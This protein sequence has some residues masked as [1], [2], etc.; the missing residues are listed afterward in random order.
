[1]AQY[2][3]VAYR[4]FWT[5][6]VCEGRRGG[7]ERGGGTSGV[8]FYMQ[9][10][11]THC[12]IGFYLCTTNS[13]IEMDKVTGVMEVNSAQQDKNHA[14]FQVH[15]EGRIYQLQAQSEIE[16]K[17]LRHSAFIITLQAYPNACGW[18]HTLID[19]KIKNTQLHTSVFPHIHTSVFPH[20]HTSIIL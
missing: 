8:Y 15:C 20:I 7:E 12:G 9:Y 18:G 10:V 14:T 16:M 11:I 2:I 6:N 13:C 19:L 3:N 5:N 1:M 17:R 4:I